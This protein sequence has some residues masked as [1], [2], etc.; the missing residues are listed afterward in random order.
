MCNNYLLI[1]FVSVA[2]GEFSKSLT[3]LEELQSQISNGLENNKTVL[4]GVQESF[5][6][7]LE[8]IRKNISALEER[9]SK[10]KK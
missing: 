1:K 10:L 8:V 9:A 3:Q 5:A 6:T 4:K 2:A 7:N